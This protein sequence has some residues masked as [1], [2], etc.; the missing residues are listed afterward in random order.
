[1]AIETASPLEIR[2]INKIRAEEGRCPIW[3]MVAGNPTL[4]VDEEETP[5]LHWRRRRT[6]HTDPVTVTKA[7]AA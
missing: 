5:G 4:Y 1:M 6:D 7:I 2:R 3:P